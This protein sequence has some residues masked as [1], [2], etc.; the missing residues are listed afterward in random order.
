MAMGAGVWAAVQ[1]G[2]LVLALLLAL[3]RLAWRPRAVARSFA[4][5]GVRGPAYTFLAGS[6][7][8]AKRLLLAGRIGVAPLDAGC[9]DIMPILLPQFHRWVADYG[10]LTQVSFPSLSFHP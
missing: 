3:W 2:A 4:R 1:L 7:P 9:H 6:L 8:E 5:Q 10:N